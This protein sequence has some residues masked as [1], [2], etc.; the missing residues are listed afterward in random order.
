MIVSASFRTDVPAWY[1]R[2]FMK[3]L[4]AGIARVA[5]PYGGAEYAVSLRPGDVDGFVFWTRNAAPF[6]EALAEIRRRGFAFVVQ[7][8]VTGYPRAVEPAAPEADRAVERIRALA[9]AY[10]PRAVVW[11]YDPILDSTLTPP[12]WHED[13]FAHLAASLAGAVD[14]V[15]VSFAQ[16]YRKTARNLDAAAKRHG[17]AW[18]DPP[19]DE[20]R[21]LLARLA[22]IA[23]DHA[24]RLTVCSQPE[25]I[26]PGAQGASCVDA[27]RLSDVAGR[28]ITAKRKGNR[29]GC[30]CDESRDIGAYDSCAMGCAYCYAVT[31]PQAAQ[32]RLA[33]H[34]PAAESL[35][36]VRRPAPASAR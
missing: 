12:V 21:A 26:V 25:L 14:E 22:A 23:A 3:R 27:A 19:A 31:S 5:N 10:G 15:V 1:G 16:P 17:F 4:D 32:R 20:E 2:W 34:D 9:D 29:P 11:R 7:H 24:M 33:A 6:A 13:N 36:A 30:L 28:P 35:S 8:T 18:R